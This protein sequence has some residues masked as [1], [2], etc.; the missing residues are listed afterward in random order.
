[1]GNKYTVEFSGTPASPNDFVTCISGSARRIRVL[2]VD[3][4]GAGATSASQGLKLA[5][6]TGGAT[7]SA[8]IVPSKAEHVEQPV[9]NFT[10]ATAWVTQPTIEANGYKIGFNALG[11]GLWQANQ[12][13]P[14]LEAR[15]GENISL[16]AVAGFTYQACQVSILIEED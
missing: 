10:T 15:N 3:V 9:S 2:R 6:S 7:P 14:A 11:P 8:A 5:R 1:M 12:K 16:R 4:S 13:T